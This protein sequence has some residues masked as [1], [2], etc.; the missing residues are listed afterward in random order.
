MPQKASSPTTQANNKRIAKN[1]LLLYIRMLFIM[2][3]LLYTSRVVLQTLGVEDF[4]T[5]GVVGSIIT[6]FTFIN[7]AMVTATQR[8]IT[9]ELGRSATTADHQLSS[10]FSS[11]L[12]IHAIISC[13]IILL[14]ETLG[15]WFLYNKLIIPEARLDAA[16]WVYQCSI[17]TCVATIM[18]V[19]YK[20]CI[21][22]HEEMSA[23]AYISVV[24]VAL[25]LAIVYLLTILP[26]DKLTTYAVLMLAIQIITCMAYMLYCKR[27]YAATTYRHAINR[28]LLCEM[29]SFAGWSFWGNLAYVL[30]TQGINML[31]NTFFGIVVNAAREFAVQIQTAVSQF[32][33]NFQMAL[34]PQITKTYA[35][36]ELHEMHTLIHRSSRF[37]FFLLYFL[38]LP[39]IIEAPYLLSLWL[40]T[41]PPHTAIF[42]R[43]LLVCSLISATAGS[44]VVANQATGKVKR[45]Q[46]I[47]GGILLLSLPISYATLSL[48]APAHAVFIVAI[49]IELIAQTARL[50]LLRPLIA[51]SLREFAKG[52]YTPILAV[53][54]TSLPLPLIASASLPQG[55]ARLVVVCACSILATSLFTFALGL[56]KNERSFI[57]DKI[58]NRIRING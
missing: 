32:V 9:F 12:Q 39:V 24:E 3:V 28:P 20:A 38:A 14:G 7:A 48:G 49:G 17:M 35:A 36:G 51:L 44:C 29:A 27:H 15:L 31:L 54:L 58:K 23:F 10:V 11:S 57:I 47:V 2:G 56:T 22:A 52:V 4:G 30:N 21:I 41:V 26:S 40:D 46:A 1:T 55:F 19:P 33:G 37:S 45:Y 50:L 42:T 18:V 43:L 6:M 5:Y 16:F 34:N 8:Y 25:K 53:M 13:I